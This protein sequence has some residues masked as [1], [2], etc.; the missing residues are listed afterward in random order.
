MTLPSNSTSAECNNSVC[1]PGIGLGAILS[2]TKLVPPELL[3]AATKAIAAAAPA[4]RD[5]T[6]P[7]LPDVENVREVSVEIAAGVIK[8]AVEM[9]LAQEE[10]IPLNDDI[11]KDFIREQMW[12]A[13]YRD[14]RRVSVEEATK[15]AKG[16]AGMG[17]SH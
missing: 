3:V 8:A 15:H 14:L 10:D 6:G 9:G 11:L 12:D 13:T 7:L 17:R 1:F 4:L 2:R 16:E 5:P